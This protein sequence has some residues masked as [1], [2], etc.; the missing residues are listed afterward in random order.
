MEVCKSFFPGIYL[1]EKCTPEDV[2]YQLD[3]NED[4]EKIWENIFRCFGI[5]DGITFVIL[6]VQLFSQTGV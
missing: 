5:A 4:R 2:V 6:W 3:Y 1:F